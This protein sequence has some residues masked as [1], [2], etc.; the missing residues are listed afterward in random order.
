M[1]FK[2]WNFCL[3]LICFFLC[4]DKLILQEFWRHSIWENASG[5]TNGLTEPHGN[6]SWNCQEQSFAGECV[7]DISLHVEPHPCLCGWETWLWEN[8]GPAAHLQVMVLSI[9]H[10]FLWIQQFRVSDVQE[11]FFWVFKV[12]FFG[13]KGWGFLMYKRVFLICKVFS[14]GIYYSMSGWQEKTMV[15]FTSPLLLDL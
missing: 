7:C 9:T 14:K 10:L 2:L 1:T 6:S 5:W 15:D 3:F 4:V 8:P 11:F 12:Y 13:F